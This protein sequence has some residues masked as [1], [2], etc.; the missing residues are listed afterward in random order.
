MDGMEEYSKMFEEA[1]RRQQIALLAEVE[2][3]RTMHE[4]IDG[5]NEKDLGTFKSIVS[6][7]AR[8]SDPAYTA[9]YWR[10]YAKGLLHS[11]H[12]IAPWQSVASDDD[13]KDL[14]GEGTDE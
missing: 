4:F 7:C 9:N 13:F 6:Q 12:N 5:L 11:K 8:A 14:L 1:A 2:K 3:D 10:A